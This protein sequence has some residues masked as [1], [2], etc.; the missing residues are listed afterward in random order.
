M[1]YSLAA[2]QIKKAPQ[3]SSELELWGLS[4]S[5]ALRWRILD[6]LRSACCQF[7]KL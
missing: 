1:C 2:V 7:L 4:L 6:A 3:F 5:G